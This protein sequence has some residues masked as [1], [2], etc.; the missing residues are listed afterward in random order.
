MNTSRNIVSRVLKL[1]VVF[2][3]FDPSTKHLTNRR[4]GVDRLGHNMAVAVLE[5]IG[6]FGIFLSCAHPAR[7]SV[8]LHFLR[9]RS[10]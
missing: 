7:R 1:I 10:S 3:H 6:L 8:H 4:K 9:Y 2:D 5:F